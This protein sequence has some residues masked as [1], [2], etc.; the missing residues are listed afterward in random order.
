[1]SIAEQIARAK[2][3]YDEVYAA[4]EKTEYDKF[5]DNFQENGNRVQYPYS[6]YYPFWND[7]NYNPKYP[8]VIDAS[9]NTQSTFSYS[10]ITDTKVDI[11]IKS[12]VQQTFYRCYELVT[13]KKLIVTETATFTNAFRDCSALENLTVEGTIAAD[14]NL[15]YSPKLTHDSLMSVINALKDYSESGT[16]YTLTIGNTNLEKL[17]DIEIDI[18]Y[19]KGWDIV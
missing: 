18:A 10:E 2:T 8:I 4:G 12:Q 6:F 19:Q 1:M 13:I 7:K 5:W 9:G 16:T 3:D 11:T 14:P 17:T 15:S